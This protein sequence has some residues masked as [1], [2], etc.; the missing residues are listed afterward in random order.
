MFQTIIVEKIKTHLACSITFS[1]TNCAIL[2]I[3]WKNMA[4]LDRPPHTVRETTDDN[5]IQHMHFTCWI[6]KTTNTH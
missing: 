5:T 2:E 1:V 4:D 6:T 3:M